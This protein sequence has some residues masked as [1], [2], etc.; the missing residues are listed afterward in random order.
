MKTILYIVVGI[1][2]LTFCA[3][4]YRQHK[5]DYK[6]RVFWYTPVFCIAFALFLLL[7]LVANVASFMAAVVIL[8]VLLIFVPLFAFGIGWLF[9]TLLSG[10]KR[11]R[12][13]FAVGVLGCFLLPIAAVAYLE[14]TI[15]QH[16]KHI[17]DQFVA[18]QNTTLQVRLGGQK[19]SIPAYPRITISYECSPGKYCHASFSRMSASNVNSLQTLRTAATLQLIEIRSSSRF[20]G[21]NTPSKHNCEETSDF[22]QWC[23]RRADLLAKAWC[24]ALPDVEVR[25]EY[26]E[27]WREKPWF[28]RGMAVVD[29][30]E[31]IESED[32]LKY[33]LMCGPKSSTRCKSVY[34]ITPNLRITTSY[35][36][37]PRED[38]PALAWE[39]HAKTKRIWNL[40]TRVEQP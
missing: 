5:P 15:F 4:L 28:A 18:F 29:I 22:N 2:L 40:M 34:K 12:I 24:E 31:G 21:C 11:F 33:E 27:D 13:V 25:I 8:V 20:G 26:R 32:H 36:W 9:A 23:T 30:S 6:P 17:R 38:V 7:V 16:E 1:Y 39:T 37:L 14:Y 19:V 10:L 3:T 35:P